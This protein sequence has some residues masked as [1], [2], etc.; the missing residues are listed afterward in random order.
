MKMKSV[1]IAKLEAPGLYSSA[2]IVNGLQNNFEEV[3]EFNYQNVM[4]MEGASEMRR[5]LMGM[6]LMY[7][8]DIVFLHVQIPEPLDMNLMEFL[9]ERTYV[10]MYTFDVRTDISWYKEYAPLVG[11]IVFADK[12]SVLECVSEGIKNVDYLHSSANYEQYKPLPE[13]KLPEKDYGEI[14]FIGNNFIGTIHKFPNTGQRFEL[15]QFMQ[16][17]FGDRFKA[18]GLGWRGSR[19]LS[20]AEEI[21]AYQSCKIAITHNNFNRSG[22]TSDRQWRSMGCGALTIC[23]YYDGYYDDIPSQMSQTWSTF[24][25]LEHRCQILLDNDGFRRQVAIRQ[26]KH[27]VDNHNWTIRFS[28]L[29]K[30]IL[31]HGYETR[32]EDIARRAASTSR[33]S[34]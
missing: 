17:K 24:H 5:R 2:G 13:G 27:V 29:K 20:P 23:H 19:M 14:I 12:E 6:V 31:N 10:V 26:H 32:V 8:P 9:S 7:K 28:K 33:S 3:Y 15:V 4:Y 11:L 1:L 34:L 21:A 22:Y 18:Y 16:D 25:K 30:L